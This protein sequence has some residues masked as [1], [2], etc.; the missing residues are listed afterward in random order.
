MSRARAKR[1]SRAAVAWID[2][3]DN[4]LDRAVVALLGALGISA[5]A[6]PAFALPLIGVIIAIAVVRAVKERIG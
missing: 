4:E 2:R 1:P 5:F 6:V 3:T